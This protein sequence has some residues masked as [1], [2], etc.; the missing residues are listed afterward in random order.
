MRRRLLGIIGLVGLLTLALAACGGQRATPTSRPTVSPIPV[1]S[2]PTV[3]EAPALATLAAVT[4]TAA[5][6]AATP[7]LDPTAVARGQSNWERL[8]CATCHG[9]NGEGGVG[10]IGGKVAPSLAGLTLTQEEF[11]TWMRTGGTL[12]NAHLFS[13]DRL[14]DSGGRNLYQF[15]LSL[16]GGE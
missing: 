1:Y 10:S 3:T 2:Y 16:S 15:V 12:G 13:T 9:E 8:G 6:G 14:S 7:V 5:A 11:I 4:A